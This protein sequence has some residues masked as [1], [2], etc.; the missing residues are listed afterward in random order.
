MTHDEHGRERDV[1]RYREVCFW[2]ECDADR[3]A[4]Y[5]ENPQGNPS[6]KG[7]MGGKCFPWKQEDEDMRKCTGFRANP[8]WKGTE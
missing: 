1:T 5:C 7:R 6:Q 2:A 3:H 4:A 8:E